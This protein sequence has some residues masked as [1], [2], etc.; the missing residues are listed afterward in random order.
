MKQKQINYEPTNNNILI[1]SLKRKSNIGIEVPDGTGSA[2]K[3]GR[4]IAINPDEEHIKVG[5]IVF[6]LEELSK[7]GNY[8][9]VDKEFIYAREIK[10]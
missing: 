6:Y 7:L 8:I 5:D 3:K 10:K 4:V 2:Q 9:I 1:E